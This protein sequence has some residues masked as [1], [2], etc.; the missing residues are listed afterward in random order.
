MVESNQVVYSLSHERMFFFRKH[1]IIRDA[2]RYGARKNDGKDEEG[3]QTTQATNVEV[4]V[5][6]AIMIE[7]KVANGI[8][9]LDRIWVRI[10]RVKEPTVVLCNEFTGTSVSP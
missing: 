10:K 7:D 6:A 4:D 8:R 1:E 2:N 9:P 3:I 5:D